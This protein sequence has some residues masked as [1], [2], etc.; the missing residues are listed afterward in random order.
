M[1]I[2]IVL[3][4]DY[5][6]THCGYG[7]NDHYSQTNDDGVLTSDTSDHGDEVLYHYTSGTGI[8]DWIWKNKG[9]S[10]TGITT[11]T[12]LIGKTFD[13]ESITFS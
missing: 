11:S 7:S 2:R 1:L 5:K 9:G 13:P 12:V 4:N 6:V 10:F 8:T 3:D